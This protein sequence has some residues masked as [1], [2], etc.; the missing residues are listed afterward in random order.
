MSSIQEKWVKLWHHPC[1]IIGIY[2]C[3]SRRLSLNLRGSFH[4]TL[5]H[6]K[7]TSHATQ[8]VT[9]GITFFYSFPHPAVICDYACR[10]SF[11]ISHKRVVL[12]R[13][14]FYHLIF[15]PVSC[16][17]N[18][19]SSRLFSKWAERKRF[20]TSRSSSMNEFSF[21]AFPCR[22]DSR[23]EIFPQS[24]LI[25]KPFLHWDGSDSS[26]AGT[27]LGFASLFTVHAM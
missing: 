19:G 5:L 18:E 17:L 2:Y 26:F 6:A 10:E 21:W 27:L 1:L 20:S 23:K 13:V 16:K 4:A 25:F 11:A 14:A 22:S 8:S 3:R 12:Q 24:E 9:A 15:S 7:Q